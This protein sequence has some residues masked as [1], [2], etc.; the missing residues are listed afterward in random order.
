MLKHTE[1]KKGKIIII[2]NEP[3][4]VINHSHSVRGRGKSVVQTKIKNLRTN[5]TFP[6]TFHAGETAEE[7]EI[8]EQN[9]I[10]VYSNRGKYIFHKEGDPSQRIEVTEDLIKE[11]ADYLIQNSLVTTIIFDEK[12]IG[13]SLP[14]KMSFIVKEAPPAMRG[15]T[16]EGGSKTVV[17][18]TG[19]KIEVPFFIKEGDV[20]EINTDT[21]EYAKRIEA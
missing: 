13:I 3:C 6:K 11:K 12:I 10:F 18:E 14:V 19:K 7:A 4:E 15:N 8:E 21:G 16:A 2:N 17:I 9:F 5:A 20:I 1:I